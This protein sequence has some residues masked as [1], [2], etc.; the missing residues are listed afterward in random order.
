[1]YPLEPQ[2]ELEEQAMF[3]FWHVPFEHVW[4]AVQVVCNLSS[5]ALEQLEL[6]VPALLQAYV[7]YVL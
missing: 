5:K 3:K 4:F 1:V 2:S 7:L 6:A